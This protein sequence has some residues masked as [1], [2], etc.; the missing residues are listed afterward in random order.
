MTAIDRYMYE[1]IMERSE[2]TPSRSEAGSC[3]THVL[4]HYTVLDD[5]LDEFA[6]L[7]REQYK[8]TGLGDPTS[9]T[10]VSPESSGSA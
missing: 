7:V 4:L 9:S 8:L 2:G 1:K 5:R 10:D 6:E 3:L